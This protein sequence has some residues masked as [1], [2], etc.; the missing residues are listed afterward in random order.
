MKKGTIVDHWLD[1][2][3]DEEIVICSFN[4][5][6]EPAGKY[7]LLNPIPDMKEGQAG[8]LWEVDKRC[9]GLKKIS[10]P[11]LKLVLGCFVNNLHLS[12]L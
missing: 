10:R 6:F 8:E 2:A 3:V 4:D 9:T 11:C 5:S 7:V 1:G 12:F